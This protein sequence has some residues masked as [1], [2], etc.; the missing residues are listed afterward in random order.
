MSTKSKLFGSMV[1][2]ALLGGVAACGGGAQIGAPET[3]SPTQVEQPT[4]KEGPTS[5][6]TATKNETELV[7]LAGVERNGTCP[8]PNEQAIK[9]P[10]ANRSHESGPWGRIEW[11]GRKIR[12]DLA[13]STALWLCVS[14]G[15]KSM[16]Y[17]LPP[18]DRE[19]ASLC[20]RSA[21]SFKTLIDIDHVVY[22]VTHFAPEANEE[23]IEL[24]FHESK[25][26]D[27][28]QILGTRGEVALNRDGSDSD[29][30]IVKGRPTIAAEQAVEAGAYIPNVEGAPGCPPQSP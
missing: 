21:A 17:E 11:S 2:L 26:D 8:R 25:A 19:A 15:Q 6:A 1:G 14:D 4:T 13:R 10:S 30:R 16:I 20:G 29:Y 3:T 7:T 9:V 28:E 24:C 23:H 12:Y 27:M 22:I 18:C 5:D